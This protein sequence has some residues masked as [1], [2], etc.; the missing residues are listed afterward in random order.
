MSAPLLSKSPTIL[1]MFGAFEWLGSTKLDKE[2]L[3]VLLCLFVVYKR[4]HG[5]LLSLF[6]RLCCHYCQKSGVSTRCLD[7]YPEWHIAQYYVCFP[8][9]QKAD[10]ATNVCGFCGRPWSHQNTPLW[11]KC[12]S[13]PVCRLQSQHQC[14]LYPLIQAGF[15]PKV[16]SLD[17]M[18]AGFSWASAMSFLCCCSNVIFWLFR[19][20]KTLS[21]LLCPQ[22][23]VRTVHIKILP[24]SFHVMETQCTSVKRMQED[25]KIVPAAGC[26]GASP[27][28]ANPGEWGARLSR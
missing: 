25:P 4:L 3:Y 2:N 15:P 12:L 6:H 9:L 17:Y 26:T 14:F 5:W 13:V 21:S 22:P 10:N 18:S 23:W 28:L 27:V 16:L 8:T 20:R 1:Q 7:F 11:R 24:L 19:D